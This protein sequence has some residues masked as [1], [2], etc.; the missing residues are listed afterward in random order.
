LRLL[1]QTT[2]PFPRLTASVK[3]TLALIS[4]QHQS[5]PRDPLTV[6]DGSF[7]G[8]TAFISSIRRTG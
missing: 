2:L 1:G 6:V 7:R 4:A 5:R 8:K 3:A